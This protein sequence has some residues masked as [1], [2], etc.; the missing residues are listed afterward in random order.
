MDGNIGRLTPPLKTVEVGGLA[1]QIASDL[2]LNHWRVHGH[3]LSFPACPSAHALILA[4]DLVNGTPAPADAAWLRALSEMN[5][6]PMGIYLVLG[7]HDFYGLTLDGA[8]QAWRRAL[9][10]TRIRLLDREVAEVGRIRIAGCTLWT[11]LDR[12]SPLLALS[13]QSRLADFRHIRAQDR[14]IRADDVLQAHYRDLN[15][16]L[17]LEG[18]S[19]QRPLVVVTHHAPSWQ[20]AH[21]GRK[22]DLFNGSYV[23]ASEWVMEQLTPTLWVHGHVHARFDYWHTQTRVV[24]NPIGY[25]GERVPDHSSA[26]PDPI[27]DALEQGATAFF[28]SGSSPSHLAGTDFEHA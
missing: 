4:G 1:L 15:W 12:A 25:Y 9:A 13:A 23:S 27:E 16:L 7:N 21:P 11:D 10:D 6:W 17:D 26:W 14:L 19:R 3:T 28:A 18:G 2:H 8:A 24:S 20:S 5:E 22:G